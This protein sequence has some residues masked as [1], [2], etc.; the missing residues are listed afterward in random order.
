[1]PRQ[2]AYH[3][4]Q[5]PSCFHHWIN[6]KVGFRATY[7]RKGGAGMKK[8]LDLLGLKLEGRHHSGMDDCRNTARIVAAMLKDGWVPTGPTGCLVEGETFVKCNAIKNR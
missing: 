2:L 6:I 3:N 5:V 1:L 7:G 8:M 4:R